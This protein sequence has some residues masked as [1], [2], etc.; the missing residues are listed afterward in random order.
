MKAKA[1]P[2]ILFLVLTCCLLLSGCAGTSS[3]PSESPSGTTGS[4][5]GVVQISGGGQAT[6][7]DAV[8]KVQN[9][10]LAKGSQP[11]YTIVPDESG[12]WSL[13]GIPLGTYSVQVFLNGYLLKS[14]T[15]GITADAVTAVPALVL[16]PAVNPPTIYTFTISPPSGPVETSG[17]FSVDVSPVSSRSIKSVAVFSSTM[18]I[19]YAL[20]KVVSS[21]KTY[22]ADFKVDSNWNGTITWTAFAVDSSDAVSSIT[23]TFEVTEITPTPSPT[24]SSTPS[25][26]PTS[27]A[28]PTATP[29]P[30]GVPTPT[31]SSGPSPIGTWQYMDQ[32]SVFGFRYV[33]TQSDIREDI[34]YAG[35]WINGLPYTEQGKAIRFVSGNSRIEV[36][37]PPF[38]E[39]LETFYVGSNNHLW[40]IDENG[41]D[42][43][44]EAV[45][46]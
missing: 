1:S 2:S 35:Q 30:S 38:T 19:T 34:Y 37:R 11:C 32:G 28:T 46:I 14:T 6:P 21:I 10:L 7:K 18:H 25:P 22:A 40:I 29:T 8:V 4:M 15:A 31:P 43:D 13:Y 42:S 9:V 45:K 39:T 24:P 20:P 3:S 41:V 33:I 26:T 16:Q 12:S 44:T 17:V 27:S 5:S 36:Y 23:A